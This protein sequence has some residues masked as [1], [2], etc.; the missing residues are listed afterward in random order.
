MNAFEFLR[1]W[2]DTH[3][4]I[5][6]LVALTLAGAVYELCKNLFGGWRK[7][8]EVEHEKQFWKS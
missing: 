4:I 6:A 2:L 7:E 8:A 1:Y 3:P 5:F